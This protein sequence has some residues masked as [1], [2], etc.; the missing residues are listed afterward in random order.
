MTAANCSLVFLLLLS[1]CYII[2][3]SYCQVKFHLHFIDIVYYCNNCGGKQLKEWI[4]VL[5]GTN[6]YEIW[7]EW[8]MSKKALEL[9]ESDRQF[10]ESKIW[11]KPYLDFISKFKSLYW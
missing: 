2:I 8:K 4:L 1:G 11:N 3:F 7:D 5:I 10:I 6:Y 9:L